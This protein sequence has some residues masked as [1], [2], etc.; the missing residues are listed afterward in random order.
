MAK[1][2]LAFI[3]EIVLYVTAF[4]EEL[5]PAIAAIP[6]AWLRANEHKS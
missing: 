4:P 1:R 5:A 2:F 6:V 3:F